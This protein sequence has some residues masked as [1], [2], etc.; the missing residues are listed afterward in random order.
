MTSERPGTFVFIQRPAT[1]EIVVAGRYEL[2]TAP[3][4]HVGYFT[5]GRSYLARDDAIALDPI[6]LPLRPGEFRTTLN[7]GLFGALRDAAPDYWGRLA[8]ERRGS[9]EHELDYLLA[10]PDVRVG[11]LSFAPET[12][13]PPLDYGSALPMSALD[14]AA[15]AAAAVEAGVAGD[16]VDLDVDP[17]LLSPSSGVGGARPKTIVIDERG[18]LWIAKFPSRGDRFNQAAAEAICSRLAETCGIDVPD[19]RIVDVDGRSVLLVRRFDQRPGRIRRPFLSAHTLLGLGISVTDRTGWSYVDLA[20]VLRRISVD[21]E[22]D[23]R[24]LYRRAIFNALISNTDDHPR[25]HA[26]IWRENGWRL[27][28]A[29][30]L[31]QSTAPQVQFALW[32]NTNDPGDDPITIEFSSDNGGSW[33]VVET[34]TGSTLGWETKSY[35]AQS[36][37]DLTDEFRLRVTAT[38]SPNN[39]I[40]E[41]GFDALRIDSVVCDDPACDGDVD[42]DGSIGLDDLLTVLGGFG[43]AGS[44]D[45]DGDGVVGLEDLLIVLGA[46]GDDC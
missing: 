23:A 18:Q 29:Y 6:H 5:Y 38:D 31:S 4:E 7:G 21:P 43:G 20:H 28:P 8:I 46:F 25:N 14:R 12:T 24:A 42:G 15:E 22:G 44:G 1:D 40:L 35:D 17:D 13:P 33:V 32:V 30:D 45:I 39:S 37:V 41:V 16:T 26:V 19:C 3:R 2:D 9:P 27:S 11:A 10:T 34:L 36:F